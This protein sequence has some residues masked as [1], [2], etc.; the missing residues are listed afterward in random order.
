MQGGTVGCFWL[1]LGS[2]PLAEFAAD[3]GA[4]AVVFDGQ[5]GLWSR[6]DL[7]NA[8]GLVKDRLIPLVRV[9]DCSR[10][11][12]S[13]ALDAGAEGVIIPL[14]ETAEQAARAI[15]W[16]RYPPAG[17]R[18]GGGVRPLRDFAACRE[19]ADRTTV[20]ALMVETRAGLE[21]I[22]DIVRTPG[23][24]MIFIGTGDL[25]LSLGADRDMEEA[26]GKIRRACDGAGIR[27]GIFTPDIDQAERRRK[28]GYCLV[29]LSDDIT[30]NRALYH[31]GSTRFSAG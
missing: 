16:S 8:L 27:C 17:S 13:S 4:E 18:S 26:I 31:T 7:E 2:V 30:A 20:V 6:Q 29:V 19:K 25:S 3:A 5:H 22:D 1:S 12:I 21:N 10:F 28:Q 14:I 15:D 11:D 9:A 23:V 24:D